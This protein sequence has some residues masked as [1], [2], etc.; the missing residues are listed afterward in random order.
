MVLTKSRNEIKS[1]R[2][3]ENLYRR[4]VGAKLFAESAR[5]S[6]RPQRRRFSLASLTREMRLLT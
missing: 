3:I 6:E 4:S 1:D 2:Q 5:G